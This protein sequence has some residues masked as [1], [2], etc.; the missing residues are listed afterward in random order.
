MLKVLP[1][2]YEELRNSVSL[3]RMP[4]K[5]TAE[6]LEQSLHIVCKVISQIPCF[7]IYEDYVAQRFSA[8]DSDVAMK[9]I[10]HNA[11]LDSALINIR[12]FNEFFSSQRQKDDI[13]ASDFTLISMDTFLAT[14]EASAINKYLA[15]ITITRSDLVSKPWFLDD[16]VTLGLKH[17]ITFLTAVEASFP[18]SS[19]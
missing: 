2:L 16:M 15:H 6:Q 19:G 3:T 10:T 11:A 4:T 12:C 18:S 5:P 13:R 17:G 1:V 7:H 14:D 8:T 9:A